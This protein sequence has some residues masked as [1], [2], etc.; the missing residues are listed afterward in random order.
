LLASGALLAS[1]GR[2][3][4][5]EMGA[6]GFGDGARGGMAMAGSGGSRGA[7]AAGGSIGGTGGPMG[8]A[9]GAAAGSGGAGGTPG[10]G[11]APSTEAFHRTTGDL[12]QMRS[13]HSAALLA[14]G[15]VLVTGGEAPDGTVLSGSELYDPTADSFT[16]VADIPARE[17]HTATTLLDGRVLIVGGND[18]SGVL[19]DTEI[20]DPASMTFTPGPSL[21]ARTQHTATLLADG[22]VLVVDGQNVLPGV[23]FVGKLADIDIYDPATN[24]FT[25]VGS[26]GFGAISN[27]RAVRLMDGRVLVTGGEAVDDPT[28]FGSPFDPAVNAFVG[29]SHMVQSRFRHAMSLLHDGRVIIVGGQGEIVTA[30]SDTVGPLSSWEMYD[31]AAQSFTLV[32]DTVTRYDHQATTLMDGRV[33]VTGG[34]TVDDA[35][36]GTDIFDPATGAIAEGLFMTVAR[37]KHTATLLQDGRVLVVGGVEAVDGT[38]PGAELFVP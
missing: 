12:H 8:E 13:A 16:V 33:L 38:G 22:R 37:T 11:G 24:S 23:P 26:G 4:Q 5:D 31:P 2:G 35:L 28:A 15:R 14:D 20:F 3:Q 32:A 29:S 18:S 27:H 19:G 17:Y 1:C 30:T 10:T 36:I 34:H 7:T 9:G 21:A 6:G 25:I